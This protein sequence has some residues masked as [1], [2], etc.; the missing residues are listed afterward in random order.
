MRRRR[1]GSR[2]HARWSGLSGAVIWRTH[3]A[4]APAP[5]AVLRPRSGRPRAVAAACDPYRMS[6]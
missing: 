4:P 2:R 3:A 1:A 5:Q 6:R